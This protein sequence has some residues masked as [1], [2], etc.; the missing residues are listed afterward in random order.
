MSQELIYF[1]ITTITTI[2]IGVI[3]Y[4]L[5]RTIDRSDK[6]E[7][8]VQELKEAQFTLSDKYAT[9]AEVAEI[10]AAMQKLSD[11]IDYIKEHTTKNEDFIRVMTRLESK[12]DNYYNR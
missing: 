8:I 12:I 11:N 9:K 2:A 6:L 5:K 7:E 1:A 4:F 3:S 10:K